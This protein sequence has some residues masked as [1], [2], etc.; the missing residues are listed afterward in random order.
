MCGI[1]GVFGERDKNLVLKMSDIIAHRGPDED[2]YYEDEE[3]SIGI[4][5]LSI[6]DLETG[7]QPFSDERGTFWVVMNGEIYNFLE[8]RKNL[9]EKGHRF[10]SKSDAE[11]IPHLYEEYGI[12]FVKHLRGMF[13]IALWDT[14]R[15]RG[16]LI[17]DRLGKTPLYYIYK[18]GRTY[19]SS[20]MKTFLKTQIVSPSINPDAL[21]LYLTLQYIPG[22]ESLINGI[23]RLLP[24]HILLYENGTYRIH[25]YWD[26]I[27]EDEISDQRKN[28]ESVRELMEESVRYRLLSDVHLAITLSGGVDSTAIAVLARREIA[29]LTTITIGYPDYPDY[30][31]RKEGLKTALKIGANHIELTL[32]KE[33]INVFSKTC[34][35]YG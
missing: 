14:E 35:A 29:P 1:C 34:L 33:D 8:I 23:K 20:E 6:I 4:K 12:D 22:E 9:G 16:I 10:R 27:F 25:K 32:R 2:G 3:C 13:A 11:V 7:N 15:K 19:F 30:D 28:I 5:R 24:G 21:S 26:I 18:N 17:R 31:E